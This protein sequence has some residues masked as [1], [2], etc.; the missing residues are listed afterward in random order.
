[1]AA[2]IEN[3]Q[4]QLLTRIFLDWTAKYPSAAAA[5]ASLNVNMPISTANSVASMMRDCRAS[6]ASN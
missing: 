5:L 6:R 1:M 4:V 2:R 3:G